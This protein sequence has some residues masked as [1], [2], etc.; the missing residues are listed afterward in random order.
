MFELDEA[1][2]QKA[3]EAAAAGRSAAA[4]TEDS[5][6]ATIEHIML[7]YNWDHQDVIKRVHAS[8]VHRGY[9]TWID[10]HDM[11]GSTVEAM[12]GAVE[13]AAVMCYGIS[14]AYKE[15]VNCRME[16]Q[17]AF[18]QQ[19]DMVPLMMEEGY[20]AKGWLGMLL[21]VR[22][23]YQFCGVVLES[24]AAFEGKVEELCRELGERGKR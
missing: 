20:R 10:V 15:S 3:K 24:E 18:Q 8:L 9:T 11:Q 2:R 12:A 23:Y 1:V 5:G 13:G 17:Y 21:G 6:V 16:A 4:S 22:L 14:R 7:S 19:V